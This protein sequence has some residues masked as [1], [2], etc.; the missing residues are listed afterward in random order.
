MR[1]YFIGDVTRVVPLVP[2]AVRTIDGEDPAALQEEAGGLVAGAAIAAAIGLGTNRAAAE[3]PPVAPEA[4][5]EGAAPAEAPRP[6]NPEV[7]GPPTESTPAPAQGALADGQPLVDNGKAANPKRLPEIEGRRDL[8]RTLPHQVAQ[9]TLAEMFR[10]SGR[11]DRVAMGEPLSKF[12]GLKHDPNIE[13][14]VM[15]LRPDGRI[16]MAE[17]VS[18][19]QTVDQMMAKLKKAMEQLPPEKRGGMFVHDPGETSG[20]NP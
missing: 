9:E 1:D 19:S 14:D 4:G 2:N 3:P 18:P 10:E 8:P 7:P 6:T 11:Y 13:P 15:G 16:D 20:G 17:V 12:S 5:A